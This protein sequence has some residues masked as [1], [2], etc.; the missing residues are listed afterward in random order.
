MLGLQHQV[1][2]AQQDQAGHQQ[3]HRQQPAPAPPHEP[4][5]TAQGE[6]AGHADRLS[7]QVTLQVVGQQIRGLVPLIRLLLQRLEADRVQRDRDTRPA[8][9]DRLR[10]HLGDFRIE[11]RAA[12][13]P[14]GDLPGQ[15]LVEHHAQ[16]VDVGAR[17]DRLAKHL[18]GGHVERRAHHH[19]GQRQ[20]FVVQGERDA[21]VDHARLHLLV[22]ED[23][24]WLE[25]AMNDAVPVGMGNAARHLRQ[26]LDA[27]PCRQRMLVEQLVQIQTVDV[28]HRQVGH[29][30]L[31]AVA[32]D[33]QDIG[34]VQSGHQSALALEAF[35][36]SAGQVQHLDCQVALQSGIEGAVDLSHAALADQLLQPVAAEFLRG[37]RLRL[38]LVCRSADEAERRHPFFDDQVPLA[39]SAAL[40]STARALDRPDQL[41]AGDLAQSEHRL[42][43]RAAFPARG[44]ELRQARSLQHPFTDKQADQPVFPGL[45]LLRRHQRFR[46][47]L[48][49]CRLCLGVVVHGAETPTRKRGTCGWANRTGRGS[50]FIIA[51]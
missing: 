40:H 41:L 43:G 46:A 22:D 32:V 9:A 44:D 14:V 13:G 34:M 47:G 5:G 49:R 28:V 42:D 30:V 8:F 24:G 17:V 15:H 2:D 35:G 18:L 7:R 4:P 21:E 45:D 19:L 6:M 25:V 20:S 29:A 33:S 12:G 16:R 26:Q 31:D 51:N 27:L 36:R 11:L 50:Y 39:G 38:G 10:H 23:V 48:G 3:R 1:Q 37:W